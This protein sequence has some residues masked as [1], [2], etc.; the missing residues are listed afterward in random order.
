MDFENSFISAWKITLEEREQS[1]DVDY[2]KSKDIY[3]KLP[4]PKRKKVKKPNNFKFKLSNLIS[5]IVFLFISLNIF[6][7]I[8]RLLGIEISFIKPYGDMLF[9]IFEKFIEMCSN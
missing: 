2:Y 5:S 7:I 6:Y 8:L 3:K 1:A 4:T 9:S